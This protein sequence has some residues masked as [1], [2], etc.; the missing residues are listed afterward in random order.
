MVSVVDHTMTMMM[1]VLD[2]VISPPV[3]AT[4]VVETMRCCTVVC[5]MM[6]GRVVMV[7]M[8][9]L[10]GVVMV[11]VV[12]STETVV[13]STETVRHLTADLQGHDKALKREAIPCQ[14][15]RVRTPRFQNPKNHPYTGTW[16]QWKKH[17]FF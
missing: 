17:R 12:A 11:A 8:V 14:D 10:D 2:S 9:G 4:G 5:S 1:V 13:A 16:K 6:A 7:V 3:M 15:Y